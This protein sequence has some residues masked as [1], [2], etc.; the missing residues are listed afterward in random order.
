MTLCN[1]LYEEIFAFEG[2]ALQ[3]GGDDWQSGQNSLYFIFFAE[4]PSI[5]IQR[6]NAFI[7]DELKK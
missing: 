2:D 3:F 7:I 6:F 1:L 5:T 4:D